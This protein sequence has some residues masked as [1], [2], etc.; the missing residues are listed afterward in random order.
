[1]SFFENAPQ[2][3]F[4]CFCINLRNGAFMMGL[5]ELFVFFV[6]WKLDFKENFNATNWNVL[7]LIDRL[8][9]VILGTALIMA[10]IKK[11]SR[12]ILFYLFSEI[13]C[14]IFNVAYITQSFARATTPENNTSNS[15]FL[16]V[17]FFSLY[18]WC[19]TNSYYQELVN[20]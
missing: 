5:F 15:F 16:F 11:N 12:I 7:F 19:V 18:G 13:I 6:Y 3:S 2:C 10:V 4:C 14:I 17:I 20:Y 9:E 1:M 8:F